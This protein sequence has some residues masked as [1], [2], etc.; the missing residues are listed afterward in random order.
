M[1]DPERYDWSRLEIVFYY[2]E[3][4]GDVFRAWT[5]SEGLEAFFVER[6]RFTSPDGIERAPA[7][8]VETGDEYAWAWRQ[9]LELQGRVTGVVED[10][11]VSFTFGAMNVSVF[12][13]AAGRQT[14]LHLV[15]SDIPDT[16][17]GRV[18][19]HL[20]CRSCWIFFL[21]NLTSVLGGGPDLRDAD[22]ARVSSMEVGFVPL[23]HRRP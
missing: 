23:S 12:F 11:E 1:I 6:A 9:A 15:Q 17:E 22:P 5:S 3:S 10:R 14:E 21:T 2:D 19:G 18:F 20:N 7:D 4:V 8:T 13:A 16:P